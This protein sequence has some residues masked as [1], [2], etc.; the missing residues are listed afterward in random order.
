MKIKVSAG[1]T[2]VYPLCVT[3][4][5]CETRGRPRDA[6]SL[7]SRGIIDGADGWVN[8]AVFLVTVRSACRLDSRRAITGRKQSMDLVV[9]PH[10][11]V[12]GEIVSE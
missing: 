8:K 9:T 6:I 2:K 10:R 1:Q 11:Y 5:I 12:E 3:P 4:T 7:T